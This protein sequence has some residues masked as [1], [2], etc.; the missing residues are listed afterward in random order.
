L[1]C[2]FSDPNE[3]SLELV[4]KIRNDYNKKDLPIVM[5]LNK[6]DENL[7]RLGKQISAKAWLKKPVEESQLKLILK[8][9]LT[10]K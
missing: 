1:F 6:A 3:D 7:N 2:D 9:L 4:D 8:K 10:T 5:L